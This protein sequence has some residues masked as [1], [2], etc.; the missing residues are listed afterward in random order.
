MAAAL[1]NPDLLLAR[2]AAAGQPEAWNELIALYGRRIYNLAYQF[3][4]DLAEAEDLTQEIFLRLF[5]NLRAYRGDVPLVGW[6]LKL[7]RNLCIDHFR[8]ARSQ[9]RLS[10]VPEE[11]LAHLPSAS[12]PQADARRSQQLALVYQALATLPEDLAEIIVLRDLQDFSYEDVAQ[13]LDLPL[14]TVKSRLN[15]ARQELADAVQRLL[16]STSEPA[17]AEAPGREAARVP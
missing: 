6:T 1:P 8:H 12:D 4:A 5:Q 15:R 2:R 13:A 9:N 14:G 10:R 3:T 17:T 7:S 11:V 16:S